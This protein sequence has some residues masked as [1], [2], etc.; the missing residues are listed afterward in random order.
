VTSLGGVPFEADLDGV[1]VAFS[2]SQKCLNCPPGL[3]PFTVSERAMER[4]L[5]RPD[6]SRS[7]Y[8][9]LRAILSYW[10][11]ERPG[12]LPRAYHHTAPINM[13]YAL[14]AAL[15]LVLEEGLEERWER[16][17]CAHR[18][19][20][21]ALGEFGLERLAPDGEELASLLAVRLPPS[22]DDSALR[23]SLLLDHGIEI[24]GGLGPLAGRVWRIGVMGEG[25]WPEPQERLVRA[26]ASL[27]D[28][29][30]E[31]A[32]AQLEQSWCRFSPAGRHHRS[33]ERVP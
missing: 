8:L 22:V 12:A 30:A 31:K 11:E 15:G 3:A 19:L 20:R 23:R 14:R 6:P 29:P 7:W 5:A 33:G 13:L 24:S 32:V 26:L 25:A 2:G 1:D 17:A 27:L 9:D 21:A 18:A 28:R 16:H 10:R 4:L